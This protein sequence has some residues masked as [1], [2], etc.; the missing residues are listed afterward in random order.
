MDRFV[1][2]F[3]EDALRLERG[4]RYRLIA[5]YDNP[6]GRVLREGGMGKIAGPLELEGAAEWPALDASDPLIRLDRETM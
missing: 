2:G 5:V 3:H 4:R 1:F 6:T